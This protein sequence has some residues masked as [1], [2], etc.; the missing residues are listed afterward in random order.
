MLAGN[1]DATITRRESLRQQTNCHFVERAEYCHL[2]VSTRQM[3]RCNDDMAGLF[4]L[5]DL[6]SGN[7]YFI[8]EEKLFPWEMANLARVWSM[9]AETERRQLAAWNDPTEA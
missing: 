9:L 5:E 7:R 4:G 3:E 8:E 1:F 2:L 6:N